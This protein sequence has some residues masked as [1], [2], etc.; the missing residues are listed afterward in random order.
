MGISKSRRLV[1]GLRHD[2]ISV[3]GTE[4]DLYGFIDVSI[5]L[6]KLDLSM[7]ELQ[8]IHDTNS[9]RR[10]EFN[11]NKS[12]I[13]ATQGHTIPV[14]FDLDPIEP[15]T[16]LFHRTYKNCLDSI[17]KDGLKKMKR[18]H[19][20]LTRALF[21]NKSRPI[22][23]RIEAKKMFDDGYKF[24]KTSNDVWLVDDVPAKYIFEHTIK[25]KFTIINN[26]KK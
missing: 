19:V 7:D 24:L 11:D 23:L 20:H 13:R 8:V 22:L 9:K 2:P 16:I 18:H 17:L 15:P 10:F 5:V 14:L 4:L 25:L 26:D 12:K 1:I 6:D 21:L 3:L